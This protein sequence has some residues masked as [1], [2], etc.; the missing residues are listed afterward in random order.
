M[1][2]VMNKEYQSN[3]VVS[4]DWGL[5]CGRLFLD[6][7]ISAFFELRNGRARSDVQL[8]VINCPTTTH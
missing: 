4:D 6:I 8:A 7:F 1:T 3:L 2:K 5:F